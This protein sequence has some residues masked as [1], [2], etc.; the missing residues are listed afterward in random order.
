MIITAPDKINFTKHQA[1]YGS[2]SI[3]FYL[4]CHKYVII[5]G[6]FY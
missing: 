6:S 2:V 5:H 3:F 4:F 1:N